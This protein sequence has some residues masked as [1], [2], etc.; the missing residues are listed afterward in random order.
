MRTMAESVI[1]KII[2]VIQVI[3]SALLLFR[4]YLTFSLLS[5]IVVTDMSNSLFLYIAY[6]LLYALYLA[7]V[8]AVGWRALS[9]LLY[10]KN[11]FSVSPVIATALDC[12]VIVT[13][14]LVDV[15]CFD[16]QDQSIVY[17]RGFVVMACALVDLFFNIR[18]IRSIEDG[19]SDKDSNGK[20]HKWEIIYPFVTTVV[21]GMIL[22]IALLIE[23]KISIDV[24]A[25]EMNASMAGNFES[26]TM[27]DVYGNE[28]TE[29]LLKG[30]KVTM[31]NIWETHCNPCV[32][33]M[34]YL[35]EIVEENDS[36][37]FQI[38]GLL[39]DGILN[40]QINDAKVDE[41][42]RIMETL[43]VKYT[44]LVPSPEIYEGVIKGKI[45]AFPATVFLDENGNMLKFVSGSA[46][47]AEW[48]RIINDVLERGA[49]DE[50]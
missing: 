2:S 33:E 46:Q 39:G 37:D 40:G 28:Y 23:T 26:F 22:A 9:V 13:L 27:Q 10:E 48:M 31:V 44:V 16:F 20:S 12:L 45:Q 18:D 36:D 17:Y 35:Q 32:E 14:V 8:I 47:K 7:G 34:P 50:K 30:H 21:A 43:G 11:H 25:E 24:R 38:V 29:D 3:F 4:A 1:R 41:A 5:E 6:F 49:A 42:K 15:F 19:G